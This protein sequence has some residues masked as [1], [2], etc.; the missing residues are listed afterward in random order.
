MQALCH[1]IAARC[2]SM[3]HL[4]VSRILFAT[5]QAR[6]GR[7]HG[8]QAR[9]T[10]LRF[11]G[12]AMFRRWSGVHYQVQRYFVDNREML[13]VVTFCLPRFLDQPFEDKLVT[14]FHELY[15]ISPAFDGDLRRHDGRYRLH[16]H[17]QRCYDAHMLQL[18]RAYLAAG[19]PPAFHAFLRMSF[20]QLQARHG[21]ILGVVVPRAK[22]IPVM[23]EQGQAAR[24]T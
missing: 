21:S 7:L 20:A 15:H 19:A 17:S 3:A 2:P 5:T 4:D 13:Y 24:L 9:T 16:T 23:V 18:A 22:I 10:P 1:D 12:G 14:V 6:S 11:R 8:L